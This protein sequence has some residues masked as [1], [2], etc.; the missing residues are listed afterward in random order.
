MQKIKLVWSV[1]QHI[2]PLIVIVP[3]TAMHW[4]WTNVGK[5]LFLFGVYTFR[6]QYWLLP[7]CCRT[8]LDKQLDELESRSQSSSDNY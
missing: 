4:I 2:P 8:S 5:L 6:L 3:Y 7:E 1:L